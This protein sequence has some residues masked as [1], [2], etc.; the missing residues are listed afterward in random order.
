MTGF[1]GGSDP[2]RFWVTRGL[3]RPQ[4]LSKGRGKTGMG[5]GGSG[6][7]VFEEVA[8][9]RLW[10]RGLSREF[11][12]DWL[13]AVGIQD[14]H[15]CWVNPRKTVDYQ[16]TSHSDLARHLCSRAHVLGFP[17][18]LLHSQKQGLPGIRY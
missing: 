13:L 12:Q 14:V 8:A 6:H 17:P 7:T 1:K 10:G 5:D 11:E 4:L 18:L 3:P 15:G 2:P 16:S 9:T